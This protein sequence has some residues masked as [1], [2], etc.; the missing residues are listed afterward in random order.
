MIK[1]LRNFF[2]GVLVVFVIYVIAVHVF[3]NIKGKALVISKLENL[4]QEKVTVGFVHSTFP[5]NLVVRDIKIG[6]FIKAQEV[7]AGGGGIDI[8]SNTLSLSELR[9]KRLTVNIEKKALPKEAP[10]PESKP[11]AGV[12]EQPLT[13]EVTAQVSNTPAKPV[14]PVSTAAT[15]NPVSSA[16]PAGTQIVPP[17][18]NKTVESGEFI[19]TI[20]EAK[21]KQDKFVEKKSAESKS[22][23]VSSKTTP[24][25]EINETPAEPKK[26]P[27]IKHVFI[28]HLVISEGIIYYTDYTLG[29]KPLKLTVQNIS[30]N[31]QNFMF[32]VRSQIITSFDL[33]GDLPWESGKE[34]GTM[35]AE[36]WINLF[37]K[38]ML[39]EVMIAGL[40]GLV[41]Y[42]YYAQWVDLEGSRI[43]RA[44]LNFTSHIRGLNNDV[45]AENHLELTEIAFKPRAPEQEPKKAEKIAQTILNMFKSM[46]NGKVVFNF[47]FKTKMDCPGLNFCD[48][49]SAFEDKL[50]SAHK[51]DSLLKPENVIML[52]GKIIQG[53]VKSAS[54]VSRALLEGTAGVGLG[55]KKIFTEP[56]K[57]ESPEKKEDYTLP[58][59]GDVKGSDSEEQK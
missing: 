10:V 26:E 50:M 49:K 16:V 39:A 11:A 32:P 53:T 48:I 14:D 34:T 13:S 43:E 23:S 8:F 57:K 29:D 59:P 58:V 54:D 24:E 19:I 31:V 33:K 37:K 22:K 55:L 35:K 25:Q 6:N 5:F 42:P 45:T 36:G 4:F 56:F 17:E 52:P 18:E 9:F 21:P 41:F 2:I 38:D 30:L 46:N 27:V 3:L 1:A 28:K 47:T 51:G 7:F 20:P 44:K 40:D 15:P 12:S